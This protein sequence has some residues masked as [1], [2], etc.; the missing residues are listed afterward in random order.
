MHKFMERVMKGDA[1]AEFLQQANLVGTR[2]VA[3]FNTVMATM[4]VHVFPTYAYRDQRRY[5]QT[6]LKKPHEMKVRSFT[7]R[8][9]QLNTYL[10]Y[11][12]PDRPGQ[13]VTSLPDDDIKE[14][15]YHAMP[16]TWKK[17]MIEQ[18]YN[19][20]DGPIHAMAEFFE[21]RIENLEKSIP[22][23]VP[24]RNGK[25]S[26]KA[27]KKKEESETKTGHKFCQY[28][29]MCGHTTDECTTLKALV[30][31]A[32]QK[33][34]SHFQKKK[35]FTKHEVNIMVQKQ[36]KKAMKKNKK[37]KRTEELRAFENIS[38]SDSGQ[39]SSDSSSSEDG[40]I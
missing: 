1:K 39:E 34:G 17:K 26:K 40:E 8:L 33:K 32:K 38:V 3:N 11:F 29:G 28:H 36:V 21:T 14:I 16:N 12:P 27:S 35:R 19:Y 23:S 22:P 4:T 13:L 2:T 7:T 5:M 15:L 10:P 20:L 30:K 24:S 18:G 6:Y 9:I 25:K 37:N 31:Q